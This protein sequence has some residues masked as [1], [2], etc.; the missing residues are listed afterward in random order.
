[1]ANSQLSNQKNASA[2]NQARVLKE[3]CTN[4]NISRSDIA[5][6]TKLS[7]MT[8]SNIVSK[9]IDDH[10]VK[11]IQDVKGENESN[12][13]RK[14]IL[15]K[16]DENSPCIIGIN[17]TRTTVKILLS[18]YCANILVKKKYLLK[19]F[20]TEDEFLQ[21]IING[22][23]EIIAGTNRPILAVGLSSIG[24]IDSVMGILIDP[25]NFKNLKNYPITEA[26]HTALH[27]PVY[28]IHDSNAAALAEKLYGKGRTIGDFLY[29]RIDSGIGSGIIVNN[30]IYNGANG[31][32]GELGHLS[33]NYDGP[34]CT[35]GNRGCLENYVNTAIIENEINSSHNFDPPLT[36]EDMVELY[37]SKQR[38]FSDTIDSICSYLSCAITSAVNF[39]DIDNIILDYKGQNSGNSIEQLIEA[40]VNSSILSKG[41]RHINVYQSEL[42]NDAA[43]LGAVAI[44]LDKIFCA[45]LDYLLP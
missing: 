4:N 35:C 38:L 26:L 9:L 6:N 43:L 16:I 24:P 2:L 25:P 11:E 13:G 22:C 17:F 31:M 34:R 30:Q 10:I 44:V 41:Y 20:K 39:L 32:G 8:I 28:P 7:T 23:K 40:K 5:K 33:I 18:D 27:L 42:N 21:T 29:I 3:I 1:M 36:F 12:L 14:P 37:N 19:N 15:L 45:E